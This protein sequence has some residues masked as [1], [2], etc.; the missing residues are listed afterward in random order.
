MTRLLLS[1]AATA[2]V[3]AAFSGGAVASDSFG[4]HVSSCAMSLAP[5]DNPPA[6][7]CSHDR[8]TM[9]FANFGAMVQQMRAVC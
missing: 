9:T 4:S 1:F 2:A 3:A 8:L 7:A 6:I 5:S